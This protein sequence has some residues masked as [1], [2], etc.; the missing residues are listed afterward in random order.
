MSELLGVTYLVNER[1][2]T[3]IE[4]SE[5]LRST[6]ER[7]VSDIRSISSNTRREI[8]EIYGSEGLLQLMF[9]MAQYDGVLRM[10]STKF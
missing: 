10:E 1:E 4:N 7:F 9:A 8:S 6:S 5:L 2:I 3:S